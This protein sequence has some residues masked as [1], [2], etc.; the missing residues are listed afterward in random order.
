MTRVHGNRGAILQRPEE[1]GGPFLEDYITDYE[2]LETAT[3]LPCVGLDVD[4]LTGC[5]FYMYA[6][7]PDPTAPPQI[8]QTG[9]GICTFSALAEGF[10]VMSNF[11]GVCPGGVHF[12]TA[13]VVMGFSNCTGYILGDED[14]DHGATLSSVAVW[15]TKNPLID[16]NGHS[17]QLAGWGQ[18]KDPQNP[19]TLRRAI[20][21]FGAVYMGY[22]LPDDAMSEFDEGLPFTA[23][24]APADPSEG[25]CM[26]YGYS[27]LTS[28]RESPALP[29]GELVTWGQAQGV[30]PLWN[31]TYGYQALVLVSNDYVRKNGTTV[32]GLRLQQMLDDS[33]D[34]S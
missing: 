10:N 16:D 24:D 23:T 5:S 18:I 14:T 8:A 20:N 21:L 33:R 28:Y 3:T 30:S 27:N 1:A 22:C 11:S 19:W 13:N 29:S 12:P 25:H 32:Q 7:G 17:H 15:A 31:S 4:H 6:N 9:I 34:I 2:G 26:L